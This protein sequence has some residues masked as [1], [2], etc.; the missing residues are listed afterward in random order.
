MFTTKSTKGTKAAGR[1]G[2]ST[3]LPSTELRAGRTGP[4]TSLRT[5]K[6]F[7]A[8]KMAANVA[9]DRFVTRALRRDGW[10][11]VR[12]WEHELGW[13]PRDACGKRGYAKVV[14]RIERALRS[15]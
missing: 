1:T 3:T 5:G 11:V 7:W 14:E 9:R 15:P 2:P 6:A 12:I 4:S 13:R 10:R 8:K